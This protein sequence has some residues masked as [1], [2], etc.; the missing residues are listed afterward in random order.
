MKIIKKVYTEERSLF[1]Q[2]NLIV[3]ECLFESSIGESPLKECNNI[4]V[5]NSTFNIRYPLWHSNNVKIKNCCFSINTRAPFWYNKNINFYD[6]SI[7]SPKALREVVD[8]LIINCNIIGSEFGWNIRKFNIIDSAI[9]TEYGFMNSSD[10]DI[11]NIKYSGK[12]SFQYVTNSTIKDSILDT[13][14]AFWHS[15]NLTVIN[16][17]INGEYLGWYSENLHLINCTIKGTQPLCYCKNL[18]LTNCTMIDC[19]LA[20][21]YSNVTATINSTIDSIKNPLDSTIKSLGIKEVILDEFRKDSGN[22]VL[23]DY[24]KEE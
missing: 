1:S 19:D 15:K 9:E 16:S 14:D 5:N 21:E 4:E 22:I 3:D 6:C 2:S 12:Y 17:V 10:L 13:K 18:V 24:K 23:E 11:Q 20:F 8:G 7:Q